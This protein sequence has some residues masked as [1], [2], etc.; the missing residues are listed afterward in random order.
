MIK[1]NPLFGA[2]VALCLWLLPGCSSQVENFPTLVN[3]GLLGLST[4][5][6]YFGANLFLAKEAEQSTYLFNFL[7]GRGGPTAIELIEPTFGQVRLLMFYPSAR[8]VYTAEVQ[9]L[10]YRREWVPRGPYAIERGDFRALNEMEQA[11]NGEPVFLIWGKEHRFRFQNRKVHKKELKPEIP[12]PPPPTPT[13]VPKPKSKPKVV[14]SKGGADSAPKQSPKIEIKPQIGPLTSDQKALLIAKGFAERADNGDLIHQV[15]S[16]TENL[17][18]IVKWYT[19]SAAAVEETATA[20]NLDAKSA[21]KTGQKIIIPAG[22]V[23]ES[24]AMPANL[25]K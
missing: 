11:M 18:E 14:V 20:N 6:P 21:L 15:K 9:E 25:A 22:H 7:K 16:E 17:E 10:R 24:K 23:K 3:K 1:S 19:G 4:T 2:V 12:E 8:E 5:N 13:P